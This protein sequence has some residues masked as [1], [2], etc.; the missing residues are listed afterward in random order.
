[1]KQPEDR[2]TTL[3][4]ATEQQPVGGSTAEQRWCQLRGFSQREWRRLVFMRWLYR[5][6]RLTEYPTG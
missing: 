4:N 2:T 1:M 6:G 3:P 5:H